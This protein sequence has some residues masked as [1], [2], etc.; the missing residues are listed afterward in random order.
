MSLAENMNIGSIVNKKLIAASYIYRFT[1]NAAIS[2][3]KCLTASDA[4]VFEFIAKGG[5]KITQK[6]IK[7]L[8]F[9]REA[10]IGG[11]IR[12]EDA[13]I[14]HG[15]T[16]IQEGDKVVVFTLPSGIRKLEKFFK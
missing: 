13:Y 2:K 5:A 6:P 10:K 12:G 8:D 16:W 3:V 9:P 1:L 7:D 4:E 14:A 15:D 11:I